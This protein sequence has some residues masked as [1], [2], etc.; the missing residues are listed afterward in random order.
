LLQT[1]TALGVVTIGL[2][3]L[4]SALL[5]LNGTG[6]EISRRRPPNN[7]PRLNIAVLLLLQVG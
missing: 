5:A 2:A 1:S 6:Y 3:L 4:P 7:L